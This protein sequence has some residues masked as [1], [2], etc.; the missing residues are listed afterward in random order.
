MTNVQKYL[1]F[2]EHAAF[3]DF[4]YVS[5]IIIINREMYIAT[6]N[7]C[8]GEIANEMCKLWPRGTRRRKV[9]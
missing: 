1:R 5:D 7:L 4:S 3:L 6:S 9:L 8:K 2:E